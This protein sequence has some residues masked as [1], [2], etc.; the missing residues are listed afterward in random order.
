MSQEIQLRPQG[1]LPDVADPFGGHSSAQP[2]QTI[3]HKLHAVLRGRYHWCVLLGLVLGAAGGVWGYLSQQREYLSRGMIEIFPELPPIVSPTIETTP[4]RMYDQYM[5]TQVALMTGERILR[6]AMSTPEWRSLDR[7]VEDPLVDFQ[8]RLSVSRNNQ[9]IIVSFRDPDPRAARAAVAGVVGAYNSIFVEAE[10]A[11]DKAVRDELDLRRR[12]LEAERDTLQG[13]IQ[14]VLR[15]H[16]TD[17]LKTLH[18]ARM[19][20]QLK[21]QEELDAIERELRELETAL[22][23]T[24]PVPGDPAELTIEQIGRRDQRMEGLLRER[25]NLQDNRMVLVERLG[26]NHRAVRDVDDALRR[27]QLQINRQAEEWRASAREA[28]SKGNLAPLDPLRGRQEQLRQVQKALLEQYDRNQQELVSRARDMFEVERL[29]AELERNTQFYS[30]I[31]TRIQQFDTEKRS[32]IVDRSRVKIHESGTEPR[33]V[34]D[35][36]RRYAIAGGI[37]GIGLGF[38]IVLG[39]SLLDRR[40]RRPED[41]RAS[42]PL[43]LLGV[44]PSLPEDLADPEQAAVAAHCVHQIRTLLQIGAGGGDRRIIAVTSPASGTGKTSLALSL[45]VSYAAA[46]CRT[47]LIDCDLVGGGLTARVDT[48]VRRKIGQILQR[49]GLITQQQ[50]DMAMK[51]A[52]NSQKKLGE[53]LVDL[54]YLT[55]DDVQHAL[56]LQEQRPLGIMDV[57]A[58]EKL[59][60]CVAETGIQDLWILPLGAALPGDVSRFSPAV[61]RS[62]FA[63]ARE[64]F[65]AV[66]VDTG[67]LPG[68]LEASVVA[69]AADAVVLVVS[70]GEHR[71]LA[72]RSIRHLAEIGAVVAGMVFNRAEGRD[73]DLVSTTARLSSYGRGARSVPPAEVVT[74][75]SPKFGPMAR[76]VASRGVGKPQDGSES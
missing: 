48:I 9:L 68:S 46:N 34:R 1:D 54:G 26:E 70:R 64:Q 65:D 27:L 12:Q 29:R 22:A 56:T 42:A 3:F 38:A 63:Q 73:V 23:S 24:P 31:L 10:V 45:G 37:G 55:P 11:K 69:E 57:L 58:G 18:A 72:E 16:N 61:I 40:F 5:N 35:G 25:Q 39:L 36:R 76:A 67:P 4:L 49:E 41:V 33:L 13:R 28:L 6:Q 15:R 14:E 21:L 74:V 19:Q 2:Q 59:E 30:Q 60:N 50:L 47:L 71:P 66:L 8:S 7:R 75:D 52:R 17:D 44:L 20:Q 62:L 53:I 43:S 32:Q 51:L